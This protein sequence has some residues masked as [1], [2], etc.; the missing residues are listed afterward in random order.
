MMILTVKQARLI[1]DKTQRQMA[2]ELAISV[3]TYRKIE[4]NSDVATVEQA[5]KISEVL[6]MDYN[7][8]FFG[9]DSI[10]NRVTS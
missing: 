8:I 2:K 6:G 4:Y 7:I 9:N 3:D 5:K 10:L 1:A